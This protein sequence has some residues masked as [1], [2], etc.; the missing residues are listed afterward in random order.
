LG[1]SRND[2]G[3]FVL[4]EVRT[5]A[6]WEDG[7]RLDRTIR[8]AAE[9]ALEAMASD[10]SGELLRKTLSAQVRTAVRKSIAKRPEVVV[11]LTD[12][13]TP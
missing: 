4:G 5:L 3:G 6:V 13:E 1:V 8:E 10:I 7:G 12:E 11:V 9:G 2:S